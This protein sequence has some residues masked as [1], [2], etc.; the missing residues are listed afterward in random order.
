MANLTSVSSVR[1]SAM[2]VPVIAM[3]ILSCTAC[4]CAHPAAAA[5]LASPRDAHEPASVAIEYEVSRK[6]DSEGTLLRGR[7]SIDGRHEA[8]IEHSARDREEL[9][10]AARER[11]DGSFDVEMKYR[12]SG[13]DG[14]NILWEPVLHVARGATVNADVAGAG[15]SRAVSVRLE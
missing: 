7:T 11:N 14:T 12:E 10:F 2:V 13:P 9:R 4:A 1:N 5:P 6:G 15:W 3:A 8:A